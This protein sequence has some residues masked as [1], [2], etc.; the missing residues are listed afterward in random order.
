MKLVLAGS[1]SAQTPALLEQLKLYKYREDVVVL[2]EPLPTEITQLMAA[3]YA[4]VNPYRNTIAPVLQAMQSNV[5]VLTAT[6][7]L[8]KETGG[9]AVLYFDAELV[10]DMADKLIL[11]YKD[12]TLRNNLIQKAQAVSQNFGWQQTTALLWQ[13]IAAAVK[14]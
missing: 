2:K 5:P 8:I 4:L 1:E 13:S 3:A 14:F 10:A 9:Q 7:D 6:S 11:V 12:E